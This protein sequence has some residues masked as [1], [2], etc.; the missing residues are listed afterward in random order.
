MPNADLDIVM[1]RRNVFST[2]RTGAG[3]TFG[4]WFAVIACLVLGVGVPAV[5]AATLPAGF[6]EKVIPGPNAGSWN[7]V[8]GV[9]FDPTGRTFAWER[10]GR[11]W[12][13]EL[14]ATNF[15]Q[16]LNISPEVGNWSDYGLTGFALDPGFQT[17]GNIYLFYVVDRHHLLYF[18]TGSYSTN[19][20]DYNS[21]T[22]GRLTRYTCQATNNFIVNPAS[23]L[24]LI[25]SAKT[26]GIPVLSNTHGTGTL[27]FATDGT[28]IVSCGDGASA[29]A[30]DTGGAVS[31]STAPQGLTDGIIRAKEDIGA[32]RAQLLDCFNGK[33]LRLDPATGNGVP[34][35]PYYNAAS[36]GSI[37]SRV[38]T[39]G[40]RNP[41]RF[42]LRP[43]S[44]SHDPADGQPGV[45]YA[46]DVGWDN[47]ESLKVIT[48][49]AKNMGWPLFEGLTLTPTF[50]AGGTYDV[51]V[52]NQ[53][54]PN[55][56]YPGSGCSQYFS[57]R[58]LLKQATTN[59]ANLPP[60]N[61]PCNAGVKI[62]NSIPQFLHTRPALD[63]NHAASI[64]RT[65]TFDASGNATTADV[66]AA[67]SPVSG[68]P[69]QGNCSVGGA[70]YHEAAGFPEAYRETYF[71]SDWGQQ[72]VKNMSFDTNNQPVSV[73]NFMSNAGAV[74]CLTQHP[75][76][77]SLYYV[78]Y[79]WG[80]A[81]TIRQI[82]YTGNR[83]PVPAAATD[84]SYG[85]GPLPVQFSSAGSSDP[86]GQPITYLWNFGD[87]S[88]TS[89]TANPAHVFT[90]PGSTPTNY[91]VTLT[92]TDSGG[93]SASTT[94]HIVLN[95][96][97]PVVTII[98]PTNGTSF[99]IAA[100]QNFNLTATVTDAESS[101]AQLGYVWQ[102]L[103]HH[104][105]HNHLIA[106]STNHLATTTTD[107]IGCDGVNLYYF[108]VLLTVTD[109]VGLATTR[110][111]KIF[112]NCGSTDTPP[113][114]TDITNQD[115][116][117]GVPV[118]PL[119]F[120]IGDAQVAAANLQLSA[121]SS[122]PALVPVNNIVFGG[123]G[124]NRTVTVTPAP[125]LN[126]SATITLTVNDGPNDVSDTFLLTVTGTNTPPVL[127]NISNQS[128]PEGTPTAP[129]AFTV[130]DA[131]SPAAS[132]VLTGVASNS[133]LVPANN[134]VFGGSGSNRTVTVTPT[135]GQTGTTKVFVMADDGGLTSGNSFDLTVT[136]L[137]AGTRTLTNTT[138]ITGP[139]FGGVPP[140]P[141]TI[142][143]AGL[144]G[145]V[146]N[147]TVTLRNLAQ[148]FP[149]DLDILLVGPGGQKL[150]LMSDTGGGIGITNV[151]LTF[152]ATAASFL[153]DTALI[154]GGTYKP[155]DFDPGD[156]LASPVP[157]GPYAANFS[158]FTGQQANGPW[159]IYVS[160]D[161][162]GDVTFLSGG[163][164]LTVT[165]IKAGPQP[166]T[167]TDIPD[168]VSLINTATAALPFTI[169][170]SDTPLGSL[171]LSSAS[172]NPAL[173]PTNNIVFG[174]SGSNR[175]VT[176]TPAVGQTGTATISVFVSDGTNIASDTFLLTVLAS[177]PVTQSFTNVTFITI[178]DSGAATPYPS[179]INVADMAGNISNLT[180]TLRNMNQ[181][182]GSDVDL[183]LVGPA[184]Q[185]VI[186]M[187][188]VGSG[189]VNDVTLTVSDAAATAMPASG[190]TSGTYRPTNLTDD[191]AGGDNFPGPAPAAPYGAMLTN[192]NGTAPNGTWS[193]Y[194]FDDGVGD[195]GSFA[196]G[197]SL[198][199]TAV[200]APP[201]V[202]ITKVELLDA[203]HVRL[204]GTGN[205]NANYQ[206]QASSDLQTWQTLGT[207]TANGAGAFEFVD[208][209]AGGFTERYYR[210]ATP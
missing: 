53:D 67:G 33:I 72:V 7:E 38:W 97:P 28:L 127:S 84:Q 198:T 76:D 191:S 121:A 133:F 74:V 189:A 51:D 109:P 206:V 148:T 122:N 123:S 26:N 81:G 89:T 87:G 139:D 56:L 118:G 8:V 80:D 37:R 11:I 43:D 27:M 129:I 64:T 44:G 5:R 141:S 24:V 183:L 150:L 200:E 120:T 173:V 207:T 180:V 114:V 152:A 208:A 160:D 91:T 17:N 140:Y 32:Y 169:A 170:D 145:G 205:T 48:G 164:S 112:P 102:T 90:S 137:P 202:A 174:G 199:I 52:Y 108:R 204:T 40:L 188:D 73:S 25:G 105:N 113:T 124:S 209:S 9:T 92:V 166:P 159:S 135:V 1:T 131:Q 177:L 146:S 155:T 111:V 181:T 149:D 138:V 18:G 41:F 162:P 35:N 157:A 163:W 82:S 104:N 77:G 65:P 210:L 4:L 47:W 126:G 203:S 130:V 175:T 190:L 153:P 195:S 85:P 192:F 106:T 107:P 19:A 115:T 101:D 36:P 42:T 184:G 54:A 119:G 171:N 50:I 75:L 95:D 21:A 59:A 15:T 14:G 99:S 10:A 168:Q 55:P 197:W 167:I 86:D 125:N 61:N 16:L 128:T 68:T 98:A 194:V 143:V 158:T 57:F 186:L 176:V 110:E 13:K 154:S 151:T 30:V 49:P 70:W 193:L 201:V 62:T 3:A 34:G 69:F 117:I 66:G 83:T 94:L 39:L 179:T 182:W 22:I 132:V 185:K 136:S 29:N 161:G 79:S 93:L 78:S 187:S 58:Q 196:G 116:V 71:H 60:F 134:I 2:P 46:G 6:T 88:A 12:M 100:P 156:T 96:T 63:W 142:N 45:I 144:G 23:R 31:V 165:T 20:N 103:M 147:V 178:P 172:S